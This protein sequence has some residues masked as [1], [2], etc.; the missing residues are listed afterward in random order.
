[1]NAL[2]TC[3]ATSSSK[4]QCFSQDSSEL[5]LLSG[6]IQ[7]HTCSSALL[8]MNFFVIFSFVSTIHRMTN[9]SMAFGFEKSHKLL[10]SLSVEKCL[11]QNL[12]GCF[13]IGRI[14]YPFRCYRVFLDLQVKL[15][16]PENIGR[17]LL[18]LY[19]STS[20]WFHRWIVGFVDPKS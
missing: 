1:M 17:T 16:L 20:N 10:L 9:F 14:L 4:I 11:L 5:Q 18:C 3:I 13:A 2:L 6:G 7:I 15:A 8:S 12:L 19:Y